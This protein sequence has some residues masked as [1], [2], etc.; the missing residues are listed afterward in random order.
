MTATLAIN[1]ETIEQ[2]IGGTVRVPASMAAGHGVD[3]TR[4]EAPHGNRPTAELAVRPARP[5]AQKRAASATTSAIFS[6]RQVV[7]QLH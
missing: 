3:R 6:P 1:P 7:P 5:L 4:Q 2:K